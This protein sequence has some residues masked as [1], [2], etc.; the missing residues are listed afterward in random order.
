MI[1]AFAKPQ[2]I[3]WEGHLSGAIVGTLLAFVFRKEGP[4]KEEHHWDDEDDDDEP[5][6]PNEKP[7][8]DVPTPSNDDLN[9]R[10]HFRH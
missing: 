2:N 9:V 10:Y 1:P 3:S 7:Y 5:D 6:D 4:Q 8:W